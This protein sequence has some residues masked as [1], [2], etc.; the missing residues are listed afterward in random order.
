MVLVV[1]QQCEYPLKMVQMVNLC[2][3]YFTIKNKTEKWGGGDRTKA[4]CLLSRSLQLTNFYY[5][6]HLDKRILFGA[7]K[8]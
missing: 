7:K 2:Y 5:L 6:I 1:A 4:K 8:N 3:I